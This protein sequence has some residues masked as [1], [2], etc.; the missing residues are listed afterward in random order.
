MIGGLMKT[1]KDLKDKVAKA[2]A[3]EPSKHPPLK[4]ALAEAHACIAEAQKVVQ[5]KEAQEA[6]ESGIFVASMAT[7]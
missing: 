2:L 5:E 1:L 7:D 4:L 6:R 3:L